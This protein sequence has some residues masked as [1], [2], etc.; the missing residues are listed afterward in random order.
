[1]TYFAQF[2]KSLNDAGAEYI[3][4]G[5]GAAT[6]HGSVRL[7]VDLDIAYRRTKENATRLATALSPYSPYLR[8]APPGLPFVWD[9]QTI[10]RG[11]NFTLSTTIGDIDLLGE[12]TGG[13]GYDDLLPFA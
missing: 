4:I 7:T 11:T 9:A 8:N 3:V 1:M 5:G 2:L 10:Y 12:V 6:A 13:G